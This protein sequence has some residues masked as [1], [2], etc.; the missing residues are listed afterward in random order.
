MISGRLV[1][2]CLL[3]ALAAAWIAFMLY[4][5]RVEPYW[6]TVEHTVLS[7]DEGERIPT[8]LRIVQLSDIH[9]SAIVPDSY[10]RE[11]VSRVNALDPDLVLLTGDF[12]TGMEEW[13]DGVGELLAPLGATLGVWHRW[14]TMTAARGRP[15][16]GAR[17]IPARF[18]ASWK[19]PASAFSKTRA[20]GCSTTAS[21]YGSW[22][23]ATCGRAILSR[24]KPSVRLETMNLSYASPII[25]T[26]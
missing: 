19:V 25:P 13:A 6:L 4:A 10:I 16:T 2:R 21:R 3:G 26:R 14:A 23:W 7:F 12:I 5:F 24:G 8:G 1:W 17:N 9:R 20:S 11:C 15:G 18:A 22:G